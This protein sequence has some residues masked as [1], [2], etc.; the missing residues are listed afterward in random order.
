MEEFKVLLIFLHDMKAQLYSD[1][2]ATSDVAAKSEQVAV[3]IAQS[4]L[5]GVLLDLPMMV[6]EIRKG[7]AQNTEYLKK[8][9]VSEE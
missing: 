3:L 2:L 5:V 8:L 1:L 4:N 9:K 6:D 7:I